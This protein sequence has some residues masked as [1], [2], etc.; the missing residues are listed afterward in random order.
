MVTF[1]R[2]PHRPHHHA[3]PRHVAYAL[4]IHKHRPGPRCLDRVV[5]RNF[6]GLKRGD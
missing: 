5:I 2:P 4:Q 1:P 3:Q 6:A